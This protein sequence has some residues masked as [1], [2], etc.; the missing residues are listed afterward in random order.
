[1]SNT[2]EILERELARWPGVD[3]RV[4]PRKR[5][6]RLW[7]SYGGAE[8]F[9][10]FSKTKVGRYGLMQKLTQLRRTLRDMGAE[11]E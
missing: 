11:H 5:H 3:H 9:I 10:P 4:E 7:I 8:R 6:P 1:M 2:L